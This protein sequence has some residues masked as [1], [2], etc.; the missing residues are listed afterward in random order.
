MFSPVQDRRDV[1]NG[2]VAS[3]LHDPAVVT[4]EVAQ[5]TES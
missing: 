5:L 1:A 2:A 3:L 4:G